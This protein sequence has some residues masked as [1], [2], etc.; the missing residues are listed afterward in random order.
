MVSRRKAIHTTIDTITDRYLRELKQSEDI[1]MG[2]VID[3][4]IAV[5]RKNCTEVSKA[6]THLS[7]RVS[8]LEG[9]VQALERIIDRYMGNEYQESK[10]GVTA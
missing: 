5:Y 4:A 9:Y 2:K 1:D 10:Q 8:E 7:A 6:N 3:N